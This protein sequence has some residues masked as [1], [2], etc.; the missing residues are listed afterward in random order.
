MKHYPVIVIG[1]GMV[2]STL[3]CLLAKQSIDVAVIEA[4]RP[5]DYQPDDAFDLR[6]SAISPY[7][8]SILQQAGAWD[9]ILSK[10]LTPYEAM[11]VWDSS[12]DGQ[13]QFDAAEVG[14][15]YLG[16]IIENRMIQ[17]ALLASC[18]AYTNLDMYL[19]NRLQ[20]LE[21]LTEGGYRVHLDDGQC[22]QCD[23][24]V[25]A[26]GPNSLVRSMA[27]I[28]VK[29]DDYA[30]KGLV[31]VVETEKPH[32]ATAWQAFMPSGPLAFLPLGGSAD[33]THCS[34]VWSLPADQAD[35]LLHIDEAAFK[36]QL[37]AAFQHRLGDVV[38]ISQRAAFPLKGSQAEQYVLPHL[39]LIGD[40]AHTIHPLAGLGVNLGIK[41]AAT[42]AEVLGAVRSHKLGDYLTLR[43]YERARRGD[44]V[45]TMK[46]MEGFKLLFGNRLSPWMLL[47]NRGLNLVNQSRWLKRQFMHKAAGY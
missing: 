18:E 40:A 47:R 20:Q 16:H 42:L 27:S 12:G 1:G 37:A 33:S 34:I 22:L 17:L 14:M 44:N 13:V 10:R 43:R 4:R 26:D 15:P 29:R 24:L 35:R 7:S 3:A 19:P 39:A 9:D 28:D 25:G 45:L 38:S 21:P 31:A 23:L 2:G 11:S 30:Q 41:D 46:S 6:V 8:Q 32:Q 5:D 36:Q